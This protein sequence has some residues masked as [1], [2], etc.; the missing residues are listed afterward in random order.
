MLAE[1]AEVAGEDFRAAQNLEGYPFRVV[2]RRANNFVNS[3]GLGIERLHGGKPWNPAYIHPDDI[4][5][6][7]MADGEAVIIRSR[8]DFIVS[9][10]EADE[11]LRRGVIAMTHAFGGPVEEDDRFEGQGSSVGRLVPNHVEYD[12][13]T[14]LPRMG[15]I[16]V[17]VERRGS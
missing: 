7:A 9:V 4:A 3:N 15:N 6:L 16:P 14:G 8:H 5:A 11:T 12:R 10:L 1:L 13:V 2:P 17:R